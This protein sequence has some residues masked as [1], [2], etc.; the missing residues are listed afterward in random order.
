MKMEGLLKAYCCSGAVTEAVVIGPKMQVSTPI[1]N[2]FAGLVPL[3][4]S[5]IFVM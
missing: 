1:E 3:G 5:V 2:Y 4:T